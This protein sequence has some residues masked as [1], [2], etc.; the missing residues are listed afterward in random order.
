MIK[1]EE[2]NWNSSVYST[3]NYT[4][5][6]RDQITQINQEGQI[7]SFAYDG[8]GRLNLRTT[9]EQGSASYTYFADDTIQTMTDARGAS[10]TFA[11]NNR[12]LVTSI[13]YGVP[14]NVAATPNVSFGYDS[15]GNRTSMTD[16]LGSVSY[17]YNTLSQL[18]S[19]TRN[20]TNFGSYTLSYGYNLAGQLNSITNPWNAQIGYTYD[21]IGRTMNVTGSGYGG[22]T[23]YVNSVA[24]RAFGV[25]QLSYANTRTL[26]LQY[27]NRMRPTQW[28][29]PG[30]MGWNYF[31]SYFGENTGRVT[32]AQNIND[33]TLDRS[34]NYDHVGRLQSA[35]TGSSARAHVG[36]G[37][38]WLSDGP[39]AQQDNVYDVWGNTLSRTGWGGTNPQYS[40]TYTNNKMN[41][42]LYDDAG[43]LKDAGGGW[44]F[45]HDATS[46]QAT[47]AVGNVQM[48]YDGDRLRGKKSE[49]GVVT[50]YLRSSVLGGQLVAE[51]NSS[52]WL[53]GYVYLGDQ[54]LAVQQSGVYWMHEDPVA[55][56]TC[57]RRVRQRGKHD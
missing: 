18:T 21:K 3:T 22:V 1:V 41:G 20:F 6:A 29:I 32:Y 40:A 50:Y 37:S 44:T 43:N 12:G 14:A 10:A 27:D 54:V 33:A 39:Y 11:Y 38:N 2:L 7:R 30:V 57:H 52:G 4:Y 17:V 23:S 55:K 13:T 42:M 46:Q 45:T 8:Y 15:A 26:S 28:N 49:N 56:Q 53:R 9:P 34:Y 35:Y 31:Y 5:N 36:I 47:S 24:Y 25:K 19:E 48:F 51:V 16:G